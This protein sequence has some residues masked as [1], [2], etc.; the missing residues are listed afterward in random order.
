MKL[1]TDFTDADRLWPLA[2]LR[3][4]RMFVA[5]EPAWPF[6]PDGPDVVAAR[7]F[8]AHR[9]VADMASA[10]D[11]MALA[12]EGRQPPSICGLFLRQFPDLTEDDFLYA[13]WA[14][15]ADRRLGP[16]VCTAGA[17]VTPGR[18]PVEGA[19]VQ[20]WAIYQL[21]KHPWDGPARGQAEALARSSQIVWV[22]PEARALLDA[23]I[24]ANH[25]AL[26]AFR[27]APPLHT[28]PL[29]G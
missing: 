4:Y 21:V 18:Y 17:S 3:R 28:H 19:Q 11:H 20:Y 1:T 29:K 16:S 25:G 8:L 2:R 9:T 14:M 23:Y 15:H 5:F 10:C 13:H 27:A 24:D 12:E 26:A 6:D 7:A 22:S